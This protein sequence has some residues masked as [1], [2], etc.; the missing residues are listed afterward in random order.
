MCNNCECENYEKCPIV[1]LNT[2]LYFCCNKCYKYDDVH[3]CLNN[4]LNRRSK[5]DLKEK[6]HTI[7]PEFFCLRKN[8]KSILRREEPIFLD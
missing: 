8:K 3:T 5:V 1:G 7:F 2:S 6:H 4:L